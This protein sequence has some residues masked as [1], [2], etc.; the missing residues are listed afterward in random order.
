M[1]KKK[2]SEQNAAEVA[3]TFLTSGQQTNGEENGQTAAG[4]GLSFVFGPT[5]GGPIN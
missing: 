2:D 3:L 1:S 4:I 5:A